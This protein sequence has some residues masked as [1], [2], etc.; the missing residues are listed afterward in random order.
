MQLF[1]L[2]N[3]YLDNFEFSEEESKHCI[4]VLRKKAG[5]IIT[6][7]DGAGTEAT[8]VLE[9]DNP[10]K[11]SGRIIERTHHHP[12]RN[13]Y[14]HIAIAPTKNFDRMEWFIE[15]ATEIG[16]DEI[17]F[18]ETENSERAKVNL[19]RCQKILVSAIKQSK[20][21][22]L[23]KLNPLV[24]FK[25]CLNQNTSVKNKWIAW[26]P[27]PQTKNLGVELTQLKQLDSL[28][29]IGPE[30][31][32]SSKEIALAEQYSFKA[33]SLGSNILRTETAAL[34]AVNSFSIVSQIIKAKSS[35]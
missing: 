28:V 30:G 9:I 33:I 22:Y 24:S 31:D 15:K 19:E 26:C 7:I 25:D 23:P 14:L 32:F 1:F 6:L 12:N 8:A 5:D 13:Y 2:N 16:I 34:Y 3:L 11:C 18:I 10:K 4:R 29:L 17:T 35:H 27:T 20:Q 21:F